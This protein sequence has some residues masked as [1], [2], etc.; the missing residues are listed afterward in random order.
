MFRT[1]GSAAI[2]LTE[3]T[4]AGNTAPSTNI[5][6]G[7]GGGIFT[8]QPLNLERSTLSG[9][10]AYRNGGGVWNTTSAIAF[11]N[12]TISGNSAATGG[13]VYLS[14]GNTTSAATS[15]TFAGNSASGAGGAF[16]IGSYS[17]LALKNTIVS[18]STAGS[19]TS[20]DLGGGSSYTI[21]SGGYN[22]FSLSSISS[23][24]TGTTTGN[25]LG[26]DAKLGSLANNGGPTYTHA[27]GSGSAAIDAGTSSGTPSVDQRNSSRSGTYDIGSFEYITNHNPTATAD[28]GS[29]GEDSVL[30]VSASGVL[31]NDSDSDSDSISVSSYDS[32][33]AKGAAVK[34]NSNGSYSYDPTTSSD[35]QKLHSGKSTTDTFNYT[36]SDGKGG[37]ASTTVTIT[38]SGAED[39]PV[40]ADD[41]YSFNEDTTLSKNVLA[42][43]SDADGDTLTITVTDRPSKGTL[44]ESSDGSFSY[45]PNANENGSDSFYYTATDGGLTTGKIKVNLTINAVNDAPVATADTGS[46]SED[47]VLNVSATGVLANDSDVDGDTLTVSSADTKSAKGATVKVNSNGSYS[48][49]PTVVSDFQELHS[50]QSTTDTFNYTVSDGHGGTKSTSVTITINGAEDS[51]SAANDSYSTNE[52]TKL[53]V[54]TGGLLANDTDP[55]DGDTAILTVALDKGPSQGTLKLNSDGTFDYT[56]NANYHGAD[57]FTYTTTDGVTT[58]TKATVSLTINSVNDAPVATGDVYET[59]EDTKLSVNSTLGLKVGDSDVDGDT[60]S[61]T[62]TGDP[63]NGKL[64][65]N[66]NGSFDYVPNANYNG[67]DSFT[68]KAYDGVAYS[69]EVTVDLTIHAVND[70]PTVACALD[71]VAVEQNS[72]PSEYD[73]AGVFADLDGDTLTYSIYGNS[74]TSLV[75][76]S[77]VSGELVLTYTADSFGDAEIT[78]RATDPDGAHADMVV[79]VVVNSTPAVVGELFDLLV[80]K[81]APDSFLSLVGIFADA[82]LGDTLTYFVTSGDTD[83]AVASIVSGQIKLV[84]GEGEEGVTEITVRATDAEDAYVETTF[85]LTV[86][87]SSLQAS[88]LRSFRETEGERAPE[89]EIDYGGCGAFCPTGMTYADPEMDF[90]FGQAETECPTCPPIEASADRTDSRNGIEEVGQTNPHPIFSFDYQL[91]TG[92]V[93][94]TLEAKVSLGGASST[95]VFYDFTGLSPGD[96]IRVSLQLDATEVPT[97]D[98]VYSIELVQHFASIDVPVTISG[99]YQIFNWAESVFGN[100]HWLAELDR[101]EVSEDGA[102]WMKGDS[103]SIWFPS[104]GEGGFEA[105]TGSFSRLE[106][107]DSGWVVTMPHGDE[108]EF[109]STGLMRTRRD[110]NGNDRYY[111]YYDVLDDGF[112]SEPAFITDVFGRTTTFHYTDGLVDSITDFAGRTTSY[113]YDGYLLTAITEPDPDGSGPLPAPVTTFTHT[114]VGL[115]ET[116]TD[117]L[118]NVTSYT[119]DFARRLT[120]GTNPD[121]S[122]WSMTGQSVQ[123]LVDLTSGYGTELNPA[124]VVFSEDA[125]GTFTDVNGQSRTSSFDQYG[126]TLRREDDLGNVSTWVRDEHGRATEWTLPDPDDLTARG[127]D[128]GPL[129]ELVYHS[130]CDVC[131]NRDYILYPDGSEEHWTYEYTYNNMIEHIDQLG[132]KTLYDYTIVIHEGE[133]DEER[134]TTPNLQKIQRV[135]GLPDDGINHE[136]DDLF[137]TFTYTTATDDLP[138]GLLKSET[139]P[140]GRNTEYEYYPT[141][142][143]SYG[144][145]K[146]VRMAAGTPDESVTEYEYDAAGNVTA[147]VDP[148][149]RRTEMT[150][151]ALDRLV[152]ITGEDPDGPSNPLAAPVTSFVYDSLGRLISTTDPL[153]H[154]TTYEI[155]DDLRTQKFTLPDPDG[156]GPLSAP[157]TTIDLDLA[158]GLTTLTDPLGRITEYFADTA[159]LQQ[160]VT[161][162]DPDGE[163]SLTSPVETTIYDNF[164]NAHSTTDAL[165]NVTTYDYD[166]MSRLI[167]MTLPDPDGAGPLDAPFYEYEYFLD[168][169]LKSSTDP[170][171]R[172]T[173]YTYDEDL[174]WLTSVTQPDPDGTGGPLAAPVT[175]YEYDAVGN[176]TKVTEPSG[177]VTE[178]E[179]DNLDRLVKITAPDPDGVGSLTSPVTEYEYDAASQLLSVT[180]PLGRVTSYDYDGLGRQTKVTLPDPDG[181]GSLASP[182]ISYTYDAADRLLT[183]TDP[184]GNVTTYAYDNLDRL[185]SVTQPDP[186]GVGSLTAPV[187]SYTYDAANQLLTVTDP[188]GRVSTYTYDDLGR[189]SSI[190]QPDP[191]GVGVLTSPVTSYEY[192]AEG[193]LLSVTD[194]LSHV[195]E[196]AYDNLYRRTSIIDPLEGL[197]SFAYDAV[198]NLLSLTD[199][200]ENTTEWEYDDLNRVVLETN[201]L[202]KSRSFEYDDALD[203]VAKVDRLGR[204]TE[205]DYDELHR[206][207]AEKWYDGISL[208]RTISFDFDAAGQLLEANDPAAVNS[209]TYDKLGRVTQETQTFDG[210]ADTVTLGQSFDANNNRTQSVWDFGTTE[211]LTSDFAYDHLNRMT[212]LTRSSDEQA[213]FWHRAVFSYNSLG[214]FSEINRYVGD[215]TTPIAVA[216]TDFT[217]DGLNRLKSIVHTTGMTTWAGYDFEYDDTS[218]IT[219]IDSFLDGLIAYDY[220]DTDQL[221]GVDNTSSLDEDYEYDANGNR[222][223]SGYSTGG[224]NQLLSDGTYNYEYDDEGNRISRTNIA[225]GYVTTYDWDHRN[226]LVKVTEFDD[227]EN[228]LSSVENS[229]DASNRWIRQSVDADGPGGADA[230]DSF[231]AHDGL[232]LTL[233]FTTAGSVSG[234]D[235][236]HV[237][238]WGPAVDQLIADFTSGDDLNF[239]L[240]DHLGT[241]RD[242]I[243]YDATGEE[244]NSTSHRV[245]DSFGNN[246]HTTG[247]S[248]FIG[249]SGRPLDRVIGLQNN[250]NRWYDPGV[251]RWVSED[252]IG[253]L[254]RD[255]NFARYVGNHPNLSIDQYGL[256]EGAAATKPQVWTYSGINSYDKDKGQYVDYVESTLVAGGLITQSDKSTASHLRTDLPLAD[257][258]YVVLGSKKKLDGEAEKLAMDAKV[259][260]AQLITPKDGKVPKIQ[261]LLVTPKTQVDTSKIKKSKKWDLRITTWWCP[262]D[263]VPNQQLGIK[264]TDAVWAKVT[265]DLH[266]VQ[267]ANTKPGV[268]RPNHYFPNFFTDELKLMEPYQ[269]TT[270]GNLTPQTKTWYRLS[271]AGKTCPGV[272]GF[273]S[274]IPGDTDY[275]LV[276]HSQGTNILLFQLNVLA[277]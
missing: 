83:L 244:T 120:G 13:G 177:A 94:Q 113:S 64:T 35:L 53:S 69:K 19:G 122:T 47:S 91:S 178:Y 161:L 269:K 233:E 164:G 208:V 103:H 109:D 27:L 142:S 30:N 1:G 184:L 158:E 29:T 237:Y 261:V 144:R 23:L 245:Y 192:D 143:S 107:T 268:D 210:F 201:Q 26:G 172:E 167:G 272:K 147:I 9:N 57:S 46:T 114:A 185:T 219:S 246:T 182:V 127:G 166:E 6:Y 234:D 186:D 75:T 48:Y 72:S 126:N 226:R 116:E 67:S 33:S 115:V 274:K 258:N 260:L 87:D 259:K 82:N 264:E 225:T 214:Q 220:D 168:G 54:T 270:A 105:P 217:Y 171:G 250:L 263:D 251:G 136:T 101:L 154:V 228:E 224:N 42:N 248:S 212:Q 253:T 183:T 227:E 256:A 76:A 271:A 22:L 235:L 18:G 37:T 110:S 229:Y 273:L 50:G 16:Y 275:I 187:T 95:P 205:Y 121:G 162:P 112:A 206:N 77:I 170:L 223:M 145:L 41:S 216:D 149:D 159:N 12:S 88:G 56:P 146:L 196:Y 173:T 10:S 139:D 58:P 189:Q 152:T 14:S 96:S 230:V 55:D 174:G 277:E 84:Y 79:D 153:E 247:Y 7:E 150:Y 165:G 100:R 63:T 213:D 141:S 61:F 128:D 262:D 49:D 36:V 218:R 232:Q 40:G 44:T 134:I 195:T 80:V 65:A 38:V 70:A 85:Q 267:A 252:P 257:P 20:A 129:D 200:E 133:E 97:G 135:I 242:F 52:D 241:V 68:Y 236:A 276:G 209:Y 45:V 62:I 71:D 179:Y 190:T 266:I 231:F 181:A 207:V 66:S 157:Y 130:T 202:N 125:T 222:V 73:L 118:L 81:D 169:Q 123:G 249:F 21:S 31:S 106:A 17:S 194:P 198:G 124:P 155:H 140:L 89:I 163:G 3:S 160:I 78:V 92:T 265:H 59:D 131:G 43:D 148:L 8:Y 39:A 86:G 51:P 2:T 137:Y 74:N 102:A 238:S 4:I 28:T 240:T 93:P 34:V 60:L 188:L 191:D 180:D 90:L 104:D 25:I 119:Y 151:D 98:Y 175:Y 254:G 211:S 15:S 99:H 239:A 138:V 156:A 108:I 199:P 203:L 132:R 111:A 176:L 193:N 215:N 204:R 11:S 117:P 32:T 255:A 5:N 197:T 221:I 24:I 243:A